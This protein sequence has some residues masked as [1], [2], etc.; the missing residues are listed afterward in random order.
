MNRIKTVACGRD[1]TAVV[2]EVGSVL[3]WGSN[4]CGQLGHRRALRHR[5]TLG[6]CF[7]AL[8]GVPLVGIASGANHSVVWTAHGT[9]YAWG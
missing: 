2:T 7:A 4:R 6:T 5:G 1:H 3:T 9:A 8:Q